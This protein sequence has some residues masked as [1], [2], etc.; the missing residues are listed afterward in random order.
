M[1]NEHEYDA[2]CQDFIKNWR[3]IS[4]GIVLINVRN[5]PVIQKY[6]LSENLG[7][8]EYLCVYK[9]WEELESSILDEE[10]TAEV[11]FKNF[12]FLFS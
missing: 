3:G 10:L 9:F 11:S 8:L 7:F 5:Y 12:H 4:S 6:C 1:L 2:T